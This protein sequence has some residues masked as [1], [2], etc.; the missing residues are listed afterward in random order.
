MVR[1]LHWSTLWWTSQVLC[2]MF[3]CLSNS[4][5]QLTVGSFTYSNWAPSRCGLLNL[6]LLV[7]LRVRFHLCM[8]CWASNMREWLRTQ[9]DYGG[10]IWWEHPYTCWML[11]VQIQFGC[12]PLQIEGLD[13][14]CLLQLLRSRGSHNNTSSHTVSMLRMTARCTSTSIADSWLFHHY[15]C[16]DSA[17][18][19]LFQS[20]LPFSVRWPVEYSW[21]VLT[22]KLVYQSMLA[23]SIFESRFSYSL[24]LPRERMTVRDI[25]L[26]SS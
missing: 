3:S 1:R 8:Y 26:L 18:H 23:S 7:H 11:S 16:Y 14:F 13:S 9:I 25:H 21:S 6:R 5:S 20:C 22:C 24:W 19:S 10:Q 17:E 4:N 12:M 2:M 15:I